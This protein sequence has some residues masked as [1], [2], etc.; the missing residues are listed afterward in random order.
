MNWDALYAGFR[1]ELDK[2]AEVNLRGLSSETIRSYPQPQPMP[3][4]AY[5]KAQ[6]ILARA[7]QMQLPVEKTADAIRPDQLPQI[8]RFFRKRNKND[9]PPPGK[10]EAALSYGGHTLA[11]AGAAKFTSG[12]VDEVRQAMK[13]APLSPKAKSLALAGGAALG[14]GNKIR[15][16][17]RRKR[18]QK[19]HHP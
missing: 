8:K 19:G 16:D 5:E 2:I 6:A 7:Q 17:V 15:K 12:A 14:L 9:D 11:G 10:T 1:D 3:S 18:W 13:K 4:E